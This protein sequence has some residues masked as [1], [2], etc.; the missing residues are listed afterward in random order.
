M[1]P[2][3]YYGDKKILFQLINKSLFF[4]LM[5]FKQNILVSIVAFRLHPFCISIRVNCVE[6]QYAQDFPNLSLKLCL[7]VCLISKLISWSD[8]TFDINTAMVS[9][10]Y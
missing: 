8:I 10:K 5:Q 9:F 4:N 1:I 7:M 3:C 6:A 2:V